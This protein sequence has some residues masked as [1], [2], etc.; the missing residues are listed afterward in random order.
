MLNERLEVAKSVA[1]PLFD[2]EQGIDCSVGQI[3]ELISAVADGRA[4]AK[5]AATITQET[6]ELLGGS[7][8]ALINSRRQLVEAHQ[9]LDVIQR[10]MRVPTISWGDKYPLPGPEGQADPGLRVV[11]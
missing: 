10:Y 3:G 6:L 9:R 1:M 7:M 2:A 4:K 11:A 8:T 5:L